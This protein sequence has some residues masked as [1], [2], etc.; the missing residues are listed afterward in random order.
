[1]FDFFR[2][3]RCSN[4]QP[5][6][7]L[8]SITVLLSTLIIIF[9][10]L[11]LMNSILSDKQFRYKHLG[12]EFQKKDR[13][14]LFFLSAFISFQQLNFKLGKTGI[15]KMPEIRVIA[16]PC[17]LNEPVLYFSTIKKKSHLNSAFFQIFSQLTLSMNFNQW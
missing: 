6:N 5:Q 17:Y 13:N 1:M 4:L 11:I 2:M 8:L 16:K 9:D 7:W 10:N 15:L 12:E 14:T 3:A